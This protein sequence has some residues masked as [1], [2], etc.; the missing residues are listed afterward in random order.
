M[1]KVFHIALMPGEGIGVEVLD[2]AKAVLDAVEIRYGI[3][4]R[5]ETIPGGA[6][7]YKEHGMPLPED[8][9][10]RASAADAI[11]F[12]AMG[13]PDIRYPDGTEIAPQLDLRLQLDLYAGVRPIRTIP[14]VPRVLTNPRAAHLDF[15]IIR[16]STEG[17]FASR[18]KGKYL[19]PLSLWTFVPNRIT[20][21]NLTNVLSGPFG[22]AM[23]NSIGVGIATV[24]LG[25]FICTPA[26]FALAKLK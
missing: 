5:S 10:N 24:V 15:V 22:R 14:G 20:P 19:S 17:M 2:A 23:L 7:Y 1:P 26:A 13:W 8:G 25:L 12:G 3:R 18:G 16:E 11:L 4:F 9:I 6:H 21:A